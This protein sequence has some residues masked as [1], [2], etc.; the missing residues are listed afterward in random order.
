M[1]LRGSYGLANS[2]P[3][4]DTRAGACLVRSRL[5]VDR[6]DWWCL[7]EFRLERCD[8]LLPSAGCACICARSFEASTVRRVCS[9]RAADTGTQDGDLTAA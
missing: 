6:A 9:R 1:R 8:A 3:H 7:T 5:R 4:P 2:P